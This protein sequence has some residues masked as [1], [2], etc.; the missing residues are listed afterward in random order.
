MLMSDFEIEVVFALPDE[1]LLCTVVAS[2]GAT[3]AE[4]VSKS[5]LQAK[6][7][8]HDFSELAVGIW[9]REVNPEQVVQE[10]DRIE[11]YRLLAM[12]PREARRRLALL[13]QTMGSADH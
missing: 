2:S 12:D 11:I 13:G 4:V 5:G 9:G 3:V 7:P 1:Q 6:F 8:Q 10:G